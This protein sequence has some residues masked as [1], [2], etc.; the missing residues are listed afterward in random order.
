[1]DTISFI[2]SISKASIFA[3]LATLG[4]LVYELYILKREGKKKNQPVI[5]QFD[6]NIGT[7]DLDKK[8]KTLLIPQEF[9]QGKLSR[10]FLITILLIALVILGGVS[11]YG[12]IGVTSK[13]T[14]QN[15]QSKVIIQEIQ[16]QGIKLYDL[17]WKEIRNIDMAQIKGGDL[18]YV[19][20]ETILGSD[21]DRARIKINNPAGWDINNITTKF[22][23]SYNVYYTEY[24]ISSQEANLKI[25]AQLHSLKDGWLGE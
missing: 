14:S 1:M 9:K 3:F 20:I 22:N 2:S 15:N 10:I 18:I 24:N 6:P 7:Q 12:V 25:D 13:K 16:S 5:P 19:A 11:I 8:N 21:I 4:F 17:R 23:K